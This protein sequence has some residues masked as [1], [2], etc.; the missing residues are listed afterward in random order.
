MT[1]PTAQ[2]RKI[3]KAKT[4]TKAPT[5]NIIDKKL[6]MA[7]GAIAKAKYFLMDLMVTLKNFIWSY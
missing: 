2:L 3:C 5:T 1:P 4:D 7:K 6:M